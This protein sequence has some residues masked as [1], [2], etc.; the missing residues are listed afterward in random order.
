MERTEVESFREKCG[1]SWS[2]LHDKNSFCE[3][4]RK[5]CPREIQATQPVLKAVYNALIHIYLNHAVLN[6]DT[7]SKIAIQIL[8]NLQNTAVDFLKMSKKP[9]LD[10]TYI[11]NRIL[12]MNRLLESERR[13][14][15]NCVR[16]D[17]PNSTPHAVL[18]RSLKLIHAFSSFK[19]FVIS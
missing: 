14:E 8:V 12:K 4:S 5:K 18:T 9:A 1:Q 3:Y 2:R 19:S 10:E 15:L 6:W 7:V 11:Q 13:I 16:T 17:E